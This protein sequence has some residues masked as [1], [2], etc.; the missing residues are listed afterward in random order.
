MKNLFL[1]L[2]LLLFFSCSKDDTGPKAG[3]LK[4]EVNGENYIYSNVEHE[5]YFLNGNQVFKIRVEASG[6]NPGFDLQAQISNIEGSTVEVK[7]YTSDVFA[8]LT[9]NILRSS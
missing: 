3:E 1:L 6:D 7:T 4:I 5:Y 8:S 2:T 9:I